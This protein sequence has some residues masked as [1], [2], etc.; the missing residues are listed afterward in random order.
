MAAKRPTKRVAVLIDMASASPEIAPAVFKD[1]AKL[2][3]ADLRRVLRHAPGIPGRVADGAR[4]AFLWL[5]A[6]AS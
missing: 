2:G 6:D 4:D 1:I 5:V 3:T